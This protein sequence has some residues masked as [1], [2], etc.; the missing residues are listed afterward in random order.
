M[1]LLII[2]RGLPGSGKTTLAHKLSEHVFEADQFFTTIVD[3]VEQ[4]KFDPNIVSVA[5]QD[6]LAR[7]SA[8]LKKECATVCVSNTFSQF[9]EYSDY[10]DLAEEQGYTVQVVTVSGP[11]ENIHGCPSETI[12]RMRKCWQPTFLSYDA[13]HK[14]LLASMIPAVEDTK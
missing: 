8:A 9:W 7:T 12:N 10:L 13:Y 6:C 11:W 14:W 3:G 4:Y 2:I 5:H 1:K